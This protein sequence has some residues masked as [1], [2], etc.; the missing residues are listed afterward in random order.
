MKSLV[1]R[2]ME[3][4]DLYET[5]NE[6]NPTA[7]LHFQNLLGRGDWYVTEM[8]A[9]D[10]DVRLFGYVKSPLGEDCD[11]FGY[12][13]LSELLGVGSIFLDTGFKPCPIKEVM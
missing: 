7:H 6:E 8:G 12:F 10:D 9:T 4:P 11:E 2:L 5:E 13:M 3:V 1:E